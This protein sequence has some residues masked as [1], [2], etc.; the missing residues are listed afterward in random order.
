MISRKRRREINQEI[1]DFREAWEHGLPLPEPGKHTAE[2]AAW[3]L[4]LATKRLEELIDEARERCL[5]GLPPPKSEKPLR[6]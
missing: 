5:Q 4:R 6:H 3:L 1:S 2:E